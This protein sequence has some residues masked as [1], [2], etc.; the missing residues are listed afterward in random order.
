MPYRYTSE[1]KKFIADNVK[2]RSTAELT[3][4]F[5]ERFGLNITKTAM[6]SYKTNHKLKSGL[7][8][9]KHEPSRELQERRAFV[10]AHVE[11]RSNVELTELFNHHFGLNFT[12]KR[13][14]TFKKN[15]G[16]TSGLTGHFEKGHIPFNKGM[17]G[18]NIGG[19]ETQFKKG[20]TPLNY[21]P[22]G[23]E[24]VSVDGY[25]EVKVA[26]PNKW[27]LKHAV[28]WE[29]ENG[30]VPKGHCLIFLDG[31]KLNVSLENLHLVT[32]KQLARLN[33]NHLISDIPELTKT[34]LI[35]A[36]I[37]SKIGERKKK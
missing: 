31:N 17:K 16:F 1:Q 7:P 12:V 35:I 36:D 26:D 27:R 5:N 37:Y 23:S 34:G 14:S 3:E 4:L 33:Q 20:H 28:I 8:P 6:H 21:R 18:L 13:M 30:P 9:G 25:I 24:R 22:V 2:G 19:K 32:R 15:H 11:G 29:E 10:A